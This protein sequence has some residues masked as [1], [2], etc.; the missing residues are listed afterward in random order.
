MK[1]VIQCNLLVSIYSFFTKAKIGIGIIEACLLLGIKGPFLLTDLIEI[2]IS[3][4]NFNLFNKKFKQREEGE[5]G[6]KERGDGGR[7]GEISPCWRCR[8]FALKMRMILAL[9]QFFERDLDLGF[10][11]GVGARN[12]CGSIPLDVSANGELR[13]SRPLRCSRYPGMFIPENMIV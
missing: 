10:A 12:E 8:K 6:A 2:I 11:A 3:V 5:E 13:P 1:I 7:K 4:S 9:L